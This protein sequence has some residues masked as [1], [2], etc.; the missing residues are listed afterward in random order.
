MA[1]KKGEEAHAQEEVLQAEI[2]DLDKEIFSLR[3]ELSVNR[4][5]EKPHLL[6]EKRKAKA[7]ALTFLT[8]LQRAERKGKE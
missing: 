7:R 3:N 4:K 1:K 8:Q 2:R 5:L 6:K